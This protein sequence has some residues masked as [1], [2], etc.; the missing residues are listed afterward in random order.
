MNVRRAVYPDERRVSVT[1][2]SPVPRDAFVVRGHLFLS[3]SRPP[4][5]ALAMGV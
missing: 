4:L 5:S 1:K 2:R 3:E